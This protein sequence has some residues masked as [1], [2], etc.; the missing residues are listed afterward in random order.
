[1]NMGLNLKDYT[2][3]IDARAPDLGADAVEEAEFYGIAALLRECS[4]GIQG[5]LE[6]ARATAFEE[7]RAVLREHRIPANAVKSIHMDPYGLLTATM[8]VANAALFGERMLD[9]TP[10]LAFHILHDERSFPFERESLDMLQEVMLHTRLRGIFIDVQDSEMAA[11]TVTYEETQ[12][13]LLQAVDADS[14]VAVIGCSGCFS[15]SDFSSRLIENEQV[16]VLEM[17]NLTPESVDEVL[18][19]FPSL[20]EIRVRSA[21]Q[22]AQILRSPFVRNGMLVVGSHGNTPPDVEK[23]FGDRLVRKDIKHG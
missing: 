23:A 21:Y 4:S 8:G 9:K 16:R 1:M 5:F 15:R 14:Q 19:L 2:A 12:Q 3:R 6:D 13:V 10:V 17:L 7:V 18:P 22:V 11:D 20:L